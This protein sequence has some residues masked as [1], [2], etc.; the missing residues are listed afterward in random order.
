MFS[1]LFNFQFIKVSQLILYLFIFGPAISGSNLRHRLFMTFQN[2]RYT[3][4]PISVRVLDFH[5]LS[6][7]S[8]HETRR[9]FIQD[10]FAGVNGRR[11]LLQ[12]S[13]D[14]GRVRNHVVDDLR[15]GLVEGLIPDAGRV[16]VDR[17]TE[18]LR[19]ETNM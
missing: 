5:A 16:E 18:A 13:L 19:S 11:Q 2:A 1:I 14:R 4:E 9:P 7:V 10:E 15:P 3:F 8:D 6:H 12:E 17:V